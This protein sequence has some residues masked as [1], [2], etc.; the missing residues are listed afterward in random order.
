[1]EKRN[2]QPTTAISSNPTNVE[3]QQAAIANLP[4]VW[5]DAGTA[6]EQIRTCFQE[7]KTEIRIASGFF[8]IRGWG[9]IRRFT[10]GKRVYLL[11]GIDD[12]ADDRAKVALV[13]DIMRDLATGLDRDRRQSVADLIERIESDRFHIVDARAMD[14]HAKLY[15]VDR[16]IAI[17][18]S[19]NTTGRGFIDQ[20]EAGHVNRNPQEVTTLVEKFDAYFVEALDITQ[21]L[22]AALKR[23]L[24]L[25]SP[26]DIYLKTMLLLEDLKPLKAKYK[27]QPLSY[28]KDMIAQSLQQIRTH[29]GS[30]LVAS[31][32]LGKTVVAVW[33]ALHL[34]KQEEIQNVMVIAPKAVQRSWQNEFR[35]AGIHCDLFVHQTFDKKSPKQDRNLTV[36]EEILEGINEQDWLI[37]IDESHN[38]RNRYSQDLFNLRKNPNERLAFQRLRSLCQRGNPKVLLLTGSPYAKDIA[39]LNSQLYLLPHTAES[40]SLLP[41]FVDDAKA[42]WIQ[43]TSEFIS[44]PVASQ[45]T[46]PHV[47]KYY[48]ETDEQ[49]FY[50]AHGDLKKYLPNVTLYSISFPLPCEIAMTELIT[51]NYLDLGTGHNAMLRKSIERLAKIAWTS[52]PLAL[53]VLLERVIDTPGGVNQYPNANFLVSPEE[54]QMAIAPIIA[55][56]TQKSFEQDAKLWALVNYILIPNCKQGRKVIIFCER[57]ATVVFLKQ[58]IAELMPDARVEVTIDE[59]AKDT[60]QM[61]ET[62]EIEEAIAKFAPRANNAEG[63]YEDTFDIFI[64]T[65]AHGVGVNMQDAEVVVNYDIDWTPINPIQRAG[66]ILRF[67]NRPRDVSLYTFI[68]QLIPEATIRLDRLNMMRRWETLVARHSEARKLIDLPVL[69]TS[70]SQEIDL[71]EMASSVTIRSGQLNLEDFADGD[72]SPY[73]QH[74]ARLQLNREYAKTILN[75]ITSAKLYDG[76]RLMLYVLLRHE[77]K[78]HPILFDPRKKACREVLNIVELLNLIQSE[79]DTPTA[80]VDPDEIETLSDECVRLWCTE[81]S[82]SPINVVRECTLYLKPKGR[83][84]NMKEWLA[85]V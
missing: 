46:T 20:V 56:L 29:S 12:P 32:G 59:Y 71:P 43:E 77:R 31:T 58:G 70:T 63:K 30:M 10:Q 81:K 74:T 27:K 2:D 5:F 78:Y 19:A 60:F 47:A 25:V 67:D 33:I 4:V 35:D 42:W 80:M 6:L 73:Y 11:V 36:F 52:S 62:R 37:I 53:R 23:W 38:F 21:A 15:L 14:H 72:I 9:M 41:E 48:G 1:M 18:T 79:P 82:I 39:N 17:T 51:N 49:G 85:E 34:H 55:D 16:A 28:Q 45:L 54:R 3:I 8:T 64:S 84:D 40:R 26:W 22:L 65:D 24:D 68:P 44:L 75:D 83:G 69:T 13:N 7:A 50:I 76:D 66:R 61:K 57:Q